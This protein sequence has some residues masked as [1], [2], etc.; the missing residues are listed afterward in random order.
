LI[1]EVLAEMLADREGLKASGAA[2]RAAAISRYNWQSESG[3][4]LELYERI[5]H[6]E[7]A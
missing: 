5:L 7:R 2:G 3:R 1:A 4:L 6:A